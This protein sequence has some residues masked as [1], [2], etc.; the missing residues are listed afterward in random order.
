MEKL[1][2]TLSLTT[3]TNTDATTNNTIRDVEKNFVTEN[4]TQFEDVD[5]RIWTAGKAAIFFAERAAT[6]R[7]IHKGKTGYRA[8]TMG[9]EFDHY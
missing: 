6:T 9:P 8:G 2:H 7:K 1:I 5:N 4:R 3:N